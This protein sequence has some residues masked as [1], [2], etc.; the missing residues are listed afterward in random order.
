MLRVKDFL[1]DQTVL[2]TTNAPTSPL[3]SVVLP[4]YRR[5]RTGQLRR[6]LESVL[7][8]ACEDFELLVIDDGSTDGSAE[9]IV[10]VPPGPFAPPSPDVSVVWGLIGV[11]PL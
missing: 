3:V 7:S 5:Y 9:L 10:L 4:T 11:C 8:Q 2:R 6:A 1:T